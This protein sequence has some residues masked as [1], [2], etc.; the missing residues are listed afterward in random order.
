[1]RHNTER[2]SRGPESLSSGP[3]R[4]RGPA[5]RRSPYAKHMRTAIWRAAV[6]SRGPPHSTSSRIVIGRINSGPGRAHSHTDIAGGGIMGPGCR[7]LR[8]MEINRAPVV[9]TIL[10]RPV[11]HDACFL[12][13][14]FADRRRGGERR[15]KGEEIVAAL[16]YPRWH[17]IAIKVKYYR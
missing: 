6:H 4:A 16:D 3:R 14:V 10:A 17:H 2:R 12:R 5:T 13:P 8:E 11:E 1:M 7:K 15:R 9:R